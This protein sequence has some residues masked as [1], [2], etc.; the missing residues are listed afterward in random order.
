MCKKQ[1]KKRK[2]IHTASSNLIT[3]MTNTIKSV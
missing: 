2:F 1:K 3:I